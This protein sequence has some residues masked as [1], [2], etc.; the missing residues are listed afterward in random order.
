MN[1]FIRMSQWVLILFFVSLDRLPAYARGIVVTS[2][3][4]S[5]ALGVQKSFRVYLPSSYE[6]SPG[7]YPVIYLLHG[8]GA[9]ERTWVDDVGLA[10]AADE[11]DLR[12]IVV[13][14]DGDRGLYANGQT[15]AS[16]EDCMADINPARNKAETRGEFCVRAARYE[17]YIVSDLISYI[18]RHYHTVPRREG[19]A[20]SGDSSG[21]LGAMNLAFRHKDVFSSV[22]SH[23]GVVVPLYKGPHP[24]EAG[25]AIFM[26]GDDLKRPDLRDYV[27]AFGSNI[28]GW[29]EHSPDYLAG[30]LKNGEVA[31]YFD[32]GRED[33]FGFY[34]EALFFHDRLTA[35]GIAHEFRSATGNHNEALWR[36][37]IKESLRFHIQHF[38]QKGVYPPN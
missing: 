15:A 6:N 38:K 22:A 3:F 33:E 32:C 5:A 1:T 23:S 27:N 21:G 28:G 13:M 2:H 24:Y 7:R 34:D 20:V 8:Q 26:S 14:P 9:T 11:I 25:K 4:E 12:A 16:Y 31:I 30:R 29:R 35:L 18:D 36:Q 10:E 17:G 19:R 37:Q